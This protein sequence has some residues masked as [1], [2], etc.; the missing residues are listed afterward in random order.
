M[1]WLITA[2]ARS[3]VISS[4]HGPEDKSAPWQPRTRHR[5]GASIRSKSRSR[6]TAGRSEAIQVVELTP[7]LDKQV[8]QRVTVLWITRQGARHYLGFWSAKQNREISHRATADSLDP[9]FK[10]W[11][12][13]VFAAIA[14]G[15]V[16]G[17]LAAPFEF[18]GLV[19][20]FGAYFVW[21]AMFIFFCWRRRTVFRRDEV[22]P[23]LARIAALPA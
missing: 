12:W 6:S 20:A 1:C 4:F 11:R 13:T 15:Y 21:L 8:G 2:T 3:R 16:I 19:F 5:R 14:L 18:A 23:L 17:D 9:F 10:P 22:V 7:T